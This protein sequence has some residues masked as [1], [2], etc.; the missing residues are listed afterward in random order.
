MRIL[1]KNLELDNFLETFLVFLKIK[2]IKN[3]LAYITNRI[4]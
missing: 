4:A 2:K 1:H 3:N